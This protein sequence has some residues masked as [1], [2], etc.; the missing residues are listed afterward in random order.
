VE[1]SGEGKQVQGEIALLIYPLSE[2]EVIPHRILLENL[3]LLEFYKA[4]PWSWNEPFSG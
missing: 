4:P 1:E 3:S 2:Q